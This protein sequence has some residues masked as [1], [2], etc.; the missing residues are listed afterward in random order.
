[1]A[2]SSATTIQA[3]LCNPGFTCAYTKTITGTLRLSISLA[4]FTLTVQQNLIEAIARAA[5]VDPSRVTITKITPV[6]GGGGGRRLFSSS[7][8]EN[9]DIKKEKEELLEVV[10]VVLEP[11]HSRHALKIGAFTPQDQLKHRV[12]THKKITI[13]KETWR[14]DIQLDVVKKTSGIF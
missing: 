9:D 2:N 8:L 3:C 10:V 12:P 5:G 4:A 1:V 11:R 7:S 6:Y 13:V 14:D